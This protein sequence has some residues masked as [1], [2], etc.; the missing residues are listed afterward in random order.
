MFLCVLQERL[1]RGIEGVHIR[2]LNEHLDENMMKQV[3]GEVLH[4][5]GPPRRSPAP[6]LQ[7]LSKVVVS[8]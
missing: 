5:A 8:R 4:R 7:I 1:R 3:L 2:T 6:D